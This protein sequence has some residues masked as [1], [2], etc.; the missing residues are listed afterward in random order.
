MKQIRQNVF[1]T[2]SS[3]THS[4]TISNKAL[5]PSELR[6]DDCF[7]GQVIVEFGEYGW[8][9]DRLTR[10]DKRLSYLCTMFWELECRGLT[11]V[12][13]IVD[14]PG[15]ITIDTAVFKHTGLHI[16]LRGI[17][18]SMYSGVLAIDGYVDHQSSTDDYK[19]IADFLAQ[20]NL[21]AEEFIF[22]GVSVKISNDNS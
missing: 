9:P 1:E 21:T 19:D 22:G 3:S 5:K 2:N 20:N 8:G 12:A 16:K 17:K 18:V 15:Y 4:L 13:T 11:D 14:K 6:A 10:Q 7:T